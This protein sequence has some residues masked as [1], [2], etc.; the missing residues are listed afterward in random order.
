MRVTYTRSSSERSSG[1]LVKDDSRLGE[2]FF[3][4]HMPYPVGDV[5]LDLTCELWAALPGSGCMFGSNL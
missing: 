4:R 1:S 3:R 5:C 2:T